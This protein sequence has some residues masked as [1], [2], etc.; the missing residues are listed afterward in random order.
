MI[1]LACLSASCNSLYRLRATIST[2][3]NKAAAKQVRT[4]SMKR[5]TV[6]VALANAIFR[7]GRV[8]H[9]CD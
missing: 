1:T 2:T 6:P 8:G 7:F 3:E 4:V 5:N 9:K